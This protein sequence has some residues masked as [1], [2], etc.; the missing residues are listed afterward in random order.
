MRIFKDS[1]L[2]DRSWLGKIE[3]LQSLTT[4]K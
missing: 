1:Q 3:K 4:Q 2:D